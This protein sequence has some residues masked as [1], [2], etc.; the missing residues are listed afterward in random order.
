MNLFIVNDFDQPSEKFIAEFRKGKLYY[1][2]PELA[3]IKQYWGMSSKNATPLS[4]FGISFKIINGILIG[5]KTSNSIACYSD[6]RSRKWQG[7]SRFA[8]QIHLHG[9]PK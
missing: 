9:T 2:H 8:F 4:D 7:S 5:R 3:P 6:G 1:I